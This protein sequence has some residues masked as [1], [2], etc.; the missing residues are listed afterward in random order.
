MNF[1]SRLKARKAWPLSGVTRA[2]TASLTL[3]LWL[4]TSLCPSCGLSA[5]ERWT[6]PS[7]WALTASCPCVR[8]GGTFRL[9]EGL[10]PWGS[11]LNPGHTRTPREAL[12]NLKAWD[13]LDRVTRISGARLG[14]ESGTKKGTKRPP[15]RARGLNSH[16]NHNQH[17]LS[18]CRTAGSPTTTL[19]DGCRLAECGE[20]G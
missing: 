6:L 1:S 8:L 15:R 11:A 10:Y 3:C 19:R 13:P 20:T 16:D 5:P 7:P 12:K 18:D 4:L 17:L 2:P 9:K 14:Q